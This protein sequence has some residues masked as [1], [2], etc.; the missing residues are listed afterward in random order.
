MAKKTKVKNTSKLRSKSDLIKIRILTKSGVIRSQWVTPKNLGKKEVARIINKKKNKVETIFIRPIFAKKQRTFKQPSKGFDIHQPVSLT[1]H[2]KIVYNNQTAKRYVRPY[3]EF[4]IGGSISIECYE[5]A[6][7]S[8]INK[9]EHI[10]KEKLKQEFFQNDDRDTLISYPF[11]QS[12]D[13]DFE[14]GI[15]IDELDHKPGGGVSTFAEYRYARN[16]LLKTK[17]L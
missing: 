2:I 3:K 11:L 5:S 7:K 4:Y 6:I 8:N 16:G 12:D 10:L 9:L 15:E 17:E 13:S 14:G 1:L